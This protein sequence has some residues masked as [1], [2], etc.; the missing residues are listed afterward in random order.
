MFLIDEAD[1]ACYMCGIQFSNNTLRN[2]KPLIGS[3][4]R[5]DQVNGLRNSLFDKGFSHFRD[6]DKYT[7]PLKRVKGYKGPGGLS[8]LSKGEVSRA[9]GQKAKQSGQ[10]DERIEVHSRA[11][12]IG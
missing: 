2:E 12:R 8:P 5:K 4:F 11:S 7:R 1:L 3:G 10:S 6:T 9:S